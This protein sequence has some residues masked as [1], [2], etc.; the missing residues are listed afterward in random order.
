MN[1]D[2]VYLCIPICKTKG[3]EIQIRI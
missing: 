1:C 2:S 3:L